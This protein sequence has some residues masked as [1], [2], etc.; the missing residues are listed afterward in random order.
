MPL[1]YAEWEA[2]A[3]KVLSPSL[4]NHL[5]VA[6]GEGL[7]ARANADSFYSWRLL[8]RVLRDVSKR[9]MSVNLLGQRLSIPL[10]L[11]PTGSQA[12][13]SPKGELDTAR[14]AA[15][16]DIP[17]ILNSGSSHTIEEVA[18]VMGKK[19][20]LFQLYPATDHEI[21]ASILKRAESSGFSGIV[22][23]VDRPKIY[24]RHGDQAE[25]GA[26]TSNNYFADPVFQEKTKELKGKEAKLNFLKKIRH[27]SNFT[28]DDI[29]RLRDATKLPLIL[30]G[31]LH[32]ADAELAVA[33]HVNGI[34]VSNHGGRTMDGEIASLDSLSTI[35][36]I[37]HGKIPILFDSGIR[38][39]A[40]VVKAMAI[41]ASAVLVGHMYSYALAVGGEL[42]VKQMISNLVKEIDAA[43][44][45]CG[46]RTFGE[47]DLTMVKRY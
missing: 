15:D 39:G 46:C 23:T 26:D 11:A 29:T 24:V 43:L 5:H 44:A 41:G 12:Q 32:P 10:L 36:D 40:D 16:S 27:S 1:S 3:K 17:Y 4:F 38:C 19:M 18:Q 35:K 20:R 8:P 30:K 34:V 2:A 37:I 13:L 31:I 9:D 28:W 42:G 7:S 22:V 45:I 6:A 25:P 33:H 21:M 47:L 14:A